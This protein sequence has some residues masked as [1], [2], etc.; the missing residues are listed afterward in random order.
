MVA[1]DE[2]DSSLA[3]ETLDNEQST[4]PHV[5]QIV[6]AVLLAMEA[7]EG[8][9]PPLL[10]NLYYVLV[11]LTLDIPACSNSRVASNNL[12][13]EFRPNG[14]KRMFRYL[15]DL[16][17]NIFR[18]LPK[19]FRELFT[20]L[21]DSSSV[22]ASSD[23]DIW[24]MAEEFNL[25]L[26]CCLVFLNLL[27]YDLNLLLEKCR[28]LL[29]ILSRLCSSNFIHGGKRNAFSFKK[30]V[31]CEGAY[32]NNVNITSFSEDYIA[33][34]SFLEQSDPCLPSL[35]PMLEVFLDELLVHRPLRQYFLLADSVS[36]A[37]EI[38]FIWHSSHDD[39]GCVLEVISAHFLLSISDEH[40]LEK[41][42]GGL[43]CLHSKN[44]RVCELSL[45][46]AISLL[47]N[48]VILSAP[49]IF[50]AYLVS[51][52]SETL[53]V[54]DSIG[55]MATEN[56]APDIR[57][58][59]S[60]LTAFERSIIL[61]N[62]H[63]SALQM[64]GHSTDKNSFVKSCKFVGFP[65]SYFESYI[66]P[67]TRN[68]INNLITKLD[69]SWHSYL[70]HMFSRTK[71]DLLTAS[72]AFIREH[73]YVLEKKCRDDI[74]S[75]LHSILMRAYSENNDIL[76]QKLGDRSPQDIFL[77]ASILKL[78]G[79]SMLQAV[80]CLRHGADVACLRSLK[81][82]SSRMEY[83]SLVD[84]IGC[85]QHINI[86]LPIQKFLFDAME[87]Q[88]TKHKESKLMLVHFSGLLSLSFVSGLDFLVKC[89]IF[90]MMPLMNL[91]IFEEGNL[92]AL[93][94]LLVS[95]SESLPSAFSPLNVQ[96]AQEHQESSLLVASKFQKLQTQFSR[97]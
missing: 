5:L 49:K 27:E 14:S 19:R 50:Q 71:T 30:F 17:D 78:M 18:E 3:N 39:I 88:P 24:A 61:Y 55:G 37:S 16:S 57:F 31:S 87:A 48:P 54:Y 40:A 44:S 47:Q 96:E 92:D 97:N 59:G 51:L 29:A 43:C 42:L 73:K 67:V 9:K 25:I 20:A 93:R 68:R 38:L 76:L 74:L 12:D 69:D 60:Y 8:L 65:E 82:L 1:K 28:V 2:K 52:V 89:C 94:S 86:Q 70:C 91:F 56:M 32:G 13:L 53:I 79:S 84:I 26:R 7:P 58:M 62:R 77:L 34:L 81:E 10:K 66:Q 21:H 4:A 63:M 72:I 15:C 95:G 36:S 64:G 83:E 75:L 85:F 22:Q 46:A 33:T 11:S 41:F 6:Q 90:I 80:W 35:R 45:I 23:F